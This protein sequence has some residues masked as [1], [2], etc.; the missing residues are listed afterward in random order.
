[1]RRKIGARASGGGN[2]WLERNV[3]QGET[4]R[5]V[6]PTLAATLWPQA[7]ATRVVRLAA[8]AIGGALLL[9]ISAKIEVPFLPVPMTLQTLAVLVLGAA[10]G[11]RLAAA[12]V[13]VYLLEGLAGLPVFA[14]AI[15]GPAYFVGHTGGYLVG[16]LVAAYVVGLFA[17]R[18]WDRSPGRLLIA[19]TAGHLLVFAF[20]YA[21]LAA[22]IGPMRAYI[23]GVEP[24]LAET[25]VKTLLAAALILA[26]WRA[27]AALRRGAQGR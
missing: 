12:A 15:A 3:N 22:L 17:E 9:T 19:M 18:G 20:G 2:F 5:S 23:G 27:A 16:F 6:Q 25:V 7:D 21:W 24:F 10:Y 4:M 8:L 1:M 14:G 13:A 26:S 11:A